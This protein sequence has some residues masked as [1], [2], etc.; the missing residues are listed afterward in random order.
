ML[1][2]RYS[3]P[4]PPSLPIYKPSQ[5]NIACLLTTIYGILVVFTSPL[6]DIGYIQL[7]IVCLQKVFMVAF[8]IEGSPT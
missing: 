7:E 2:E 4:P 1:I 6:V 3:F 8:K 5:M